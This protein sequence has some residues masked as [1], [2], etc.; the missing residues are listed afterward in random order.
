[1]TNEKKDTKTPMEQWV[2]T[3]MEGIAAVAQQV[4]E[5]KDAKQKEEAL[6][7][8]VRALDSLALRCARKAITTGDE[9]TPHSL[10]PLVDVTAINICGTLRAA[11]RDL[12]AKKSHPKAW[13]DVGKD[14]KE[15]V[16]TIESMQ[17]IMSQLGISETVVQPGEPLK[18]EDGK[19]LVDGK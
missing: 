17:R 11:A 12:E 18:G 4:S 3:T 10:N 16:K 6:R 19:P 14:I 9:E 1:M 2:I 8:V 5:L 7:S 15:S 13:E